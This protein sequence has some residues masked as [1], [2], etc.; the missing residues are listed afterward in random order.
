MDSL[1]IGDWIVSKFEITVRS[2]TSV[3][4]YVGQILP[5]LTGDEGDGH[6]RLDEFQ[7]C[8]QHYLKIL[9]LL[10]AESGLK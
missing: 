6:Q 4:Y 10:L 3:N 5:T 8:F 2:K 7:N 1:S 9:S